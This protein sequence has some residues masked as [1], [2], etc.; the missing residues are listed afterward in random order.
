MEVIEKSNPEIDP[1]N[2]IQS[3]PE[4]DPKE[5]HERLKHENPKK[6]ERIMKLKA[7]R[8]KK[9]KELLQDE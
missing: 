7:T 8:E 9:L 4:V 2:E 1:N 3:N 5:Y 6:Y